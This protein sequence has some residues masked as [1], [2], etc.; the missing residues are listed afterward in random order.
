VAVTD[1]KELLRKRAMAAAATLLGA[2]SS[3]QAGK[4]PPILPVSQPVEPMP[5]E[6]GWTWDTSFMQYNESDRISVSE[7][8]IGVRRDSGEGRSLTILATVDTISGATPLGTLPLTPNTAPNTITSASGRAV[9]PDIGK[10][11]T[12]EMSDTRIALSGSYER[13]AGSASTE[14]I[15]GNVAKEHD[16]LSLGGSYTWNCDLN[17][18]NTTLSFGLSPEYDVVTPNGGLPLAYGTL[19][20]PDE[21]EGRQ[22]T[23][24]LVGGLVGLTQV[25]NRRTLMQWNYSPTYENGY[26]N[27]PYKLL[28]LVNTIG[29][30][31]SAIH[32]KRPGSR[33]EHSFYWLTRYNMREQDVFSLGLRYFTDN[34]GIR[35][36]TIDFTY[37]WQ[38]HE[39]RFLEPH[40]RYY[41]QT[42]ADFFRVGLLNGQP[43]PDQASADYRLSAIDGVTFGVRCGWT[44]QNGSELILR[45]EYYTQTGEDRPNSAVGFQKAYDLF[46]TLNATILQ[47]EYKFQPARFFAK[48]SSHSVR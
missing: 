28:S 18:K 25:I 15:A 27:D 1:K 30:P 47:V 32:E 17:Q 26:L 40:V 4:A 22:K 34:W 23:K 9:N 10:V 11:P 44:L 21:I 7:P 46:P 19:H 29:D 2:A 41:H 5:S 33:L 3:A 38:Y 48:K 16:F 14:V 6:A 39:R 45:A 43:L 42:A 13:P 8:Q 31:L 36:Q 12:S 37:R 24:Y 35:S 20:A